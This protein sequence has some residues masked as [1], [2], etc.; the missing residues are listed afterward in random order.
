M[1]DSPGQ[2]FFSSLLSLPSYSFLLF[3]F[4]RGMSKIQTALLYMRQG[5]FSM[6]AYS[7]VRKGHAAWAASMM[8]RISQ[9]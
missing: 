3:S 5:R 1:E 8:F 9:W 7:S 2:G 6:L 4:D